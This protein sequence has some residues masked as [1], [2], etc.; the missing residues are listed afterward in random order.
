MNIAC[1]LLTGCSHFG[2]QKG[3]ID[4][5][6][7][8]IGVYRDGEGC[9]KSDSVSSL[10]KGDVDEKGGH[11]TASGRGSWFDCFLGMFGGRR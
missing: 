11:T 5:S 7:R 2:E 4:L 6:M 8:F 1:L 3:E 10:G 9:T